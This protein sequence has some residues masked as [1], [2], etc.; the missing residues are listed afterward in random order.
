MRP[1]ARSAH[2]TRSVWTRV[3]TITDY[4]PRQLDDERPRANAAFLKAYV[5]RGDVGVK[6]GRG[7]YTYPD[8]AYAQPGFIRTPETD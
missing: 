5:D 8:P 4:W 3:W 1:S 2:L 6:S 7:F